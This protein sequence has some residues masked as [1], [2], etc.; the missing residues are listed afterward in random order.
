M[1]KRNHFD[2]NYVSVLTNNIS[3]EAHLAEG[4]LL[5]E[6]QRSNMKFSDIPSRNSMANSFLKQKGRI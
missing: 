1:I 2:C 5:L 3:N 4:Q 6:E